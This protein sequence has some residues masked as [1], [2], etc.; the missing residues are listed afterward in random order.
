M[1]MVCTRSEKFDQTRSES[2]RGMDLYI[3]NWAPKLRLLGDNGKGRLTGTGRCE[4]VLRDTNEAVAAAQGTV[5]LKVVLETE[6]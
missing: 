5:C 2:L 4:C 6:V 3:P 1:P